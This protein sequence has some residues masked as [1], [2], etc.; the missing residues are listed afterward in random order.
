MLLMMKCGILA[1]RLRA[2]TTEYQAYQAE[3]KEA[4]LEYQSYQMIWK[5]DAVHKEFDK[6]AKEHINN[7]DIRYRIYRQGVDFSE[8]AGELKSVI[9]PV[10]QSAENCGFGKWQ[11]RGE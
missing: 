2:L 7:D 9:L 4:Q 6:C 5:Y 1:L 10:Y 3:K 11:Y 8:F